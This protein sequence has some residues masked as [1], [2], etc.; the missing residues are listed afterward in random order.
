[1]PLA[2]RKGRSCWSEKLQGADLTLRMPLAA[3]SIVAQLGAI[4]FG[5]SAPVLVALVIA[6]SALADQRRA[7]AS[8]AA[9]TPLVTG[10]SVDEERTLGKLLGFEGFALDRLP[11]WRTKLAPLAEAGDPLAQ[12][13]LGGLYDLYKYGLGRPD[14]GRIAL[15]WYH[16]A[17]D[18]HLA[19]AERLLFHVYEFSLL[20]V[21]RDSRRGLEFLERSFAHAGGG[22]KALNALDLAR[23]YAK[24]RDGQPPPTIP[25]APDPER[26]L[27]YIEQALQLDPHNQTAIDWLISLYAERSDITSAIKLAERST[28][29][30]MIEKAALLCLSALNEVPCAVRLLER[31]R[32]FWRQYEASPP[33]ALLELYA[34]VCRKQ[35]E[36]AS[37]GVIDTPEA[38]SF[39]QKWQR[40]CVV[41]PGG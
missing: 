29:T 41:T 35:L 15:D 26:S 21:P 2:A 22:L 11:P 1:M 39:F 38:W 13:W 32:Q 14:E 12:Y 30:V 4:I 9:E 20:N 24:P 31:A 18:Q 27:R 3:R 7:I 8:Q 33:S 34:R 36:R 23:A 6:N 5:L 28:N 37:L 40:D 19:L 10:L 17:A 25:G 16:R